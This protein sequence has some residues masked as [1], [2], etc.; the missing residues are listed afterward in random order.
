[1]SVIISTFLQRGEAEVGEVVEAKLG[2]D[3]RQVLYGDDVQG[4]LDGV[5]DRA[6]V[7]VIALIPVL[8]GRSRIIIERRIVIYGGKGH[9][10]AVDRGS[11]GSEHLKGG[12]GGTRGAGGSVQGSSSALHAAAADHGNYVAGLGIAY[13]E[14]DLRLRRHF[15]VLF[16]IL[17]IIRD[18]KL[19]HNG[20][21]I[22]IDRGVRVI[23][24]MEDQVEVLALIA[25]KPAHHVFFAEVLLFRTKVHGER[26]V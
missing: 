7:L 23:L 11:K 20:V 3:H 6:D 21:S 25:L 5:A 2:R 22:F 12:T 4:L 10:A 24:R 15:D 14:C 19:R 26:V 8:Y 9:A 13:H 18:A 1:M 17:G 16:I